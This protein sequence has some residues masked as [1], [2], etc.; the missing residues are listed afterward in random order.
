MPWELARMTF[1]EVV[2]AI[3]GLRDKDKLHRDW[4]RR[5]AFIIGASGWNAKQIVAK[6]DN[7]LWPIET[8]NKPNVREAA[9]EQLRKFREAEAK[10]ADIK[11]VKDILDGRSG[12]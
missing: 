4:I 10:N 3:D 5:A 7:K 6:F 1:R 2:L 11:K 8:L 12:A 9:Y